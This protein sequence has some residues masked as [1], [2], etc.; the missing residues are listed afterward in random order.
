M[1]SLLVLVA[2][3]LLALPV[4]IVVALVMVAGLRRRVADLERDVQAL[5]VRR[6]DAPASAPRAGAAAQEGPAQAAFVESAPPPAAAVPPPAAPAPRP[7]TVPLPPSP[8]RGPGTVE[9]G[10]AAIRGWFTEGNVPVK[11]GVLV[12][13]AGVA[14]LLKYASDQGLLRVPVELRLAGIA[15]AATATLVFAWRQRLRRRAFALSLQGGAVGVLLLTVFGAFR[16]YGLLPPGMAFAL[17]VVLVAGACVLAVLQDAL[18]LAVFGILAGFLAPLWLSTGGGSHVALFSYYALLN[19]GVF[20]IAWWRAWRLLNL[21][22]FVFTFGIGTAWGVLA[23]TPT[24]FASTEP[25]LLL[26]FAFYL[27]I[28]VLYAR[29][30]AG[31]RDLVD[32]SLVFGTP[33]VAF[34]LQAALLDGARMPLALC[35][36]GLA[37]LYA[38]LAWTLRGRERRALLAQSHALLAVGF[39]TLAIPLAL[40]AQATASAFALEG[41]ALVW[42]GLRQ[43]RLLPQ[44]SGTALQALAA[45]AFAL[46]VLFSGPEHTPL[47]N[48]TCTSG[49]LV[50]LAGFASAWSYAAAARPRAALAW[51]VWGLAWWAGIALNEIADFVAPHLQP[52]AAFV[53]AVASGWLAAEVARR[54]PAVAL[55][56]TTAAGLAAGVAFALVQAW[57]VDQ[58][59]ALPAGWAWLAFA[60]FGARSLVALRGPASRAV[61]AAHAAWLWTWPLATSLGLHG[62][63][64]GPDVGTGWRHVAVLLPWWI[65]ALLAAARPAWLAVPLAAGFG[66][67][68]RALLAS[69]M[70]VL[71]AGWL[72][73]LFAAGAPAPLPWL[74]L[75]NPLDLMQ[76][77]ILALAVH[78]AATT[79]RLGRWRVPVLAFGA[80]ALANA[81]LLRSLHHW[82]GVIWSTS[83]FSTSLVQTALTLLW[84]VLGVAGWIVGSRRGLRTVWLAGA[85][86]MGVVL[87]KLVLV[88]RQHLGNLLGIVSFIGFG[89]L[90]TAVGFF[91]PAPPRAAAADAGAA[92]AAQ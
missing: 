30:R 22:G 19:A 91:A 42:L 50:A 58:P 85:L 20:A 39:A 79:P 54:R 27:A 61:V 6:A 37:A 53:F 43:A 63:L 7:A 10:V 41:A 56:W 45:C 8:P 70:A 3:V 92:G 89:V 36:L 62:L 34:A 52:A 33:L 80:F 57:R 2:L 46:G 78:L 5:R 24:D 51:Y 15:A 9:R 47:V 77:A 11:I 13:L 76:A 49:L 84:S 48:P 59:F 35:A 66:A 40:S 74:P 81:S 55:A 29:R 1:S 82:A 16:L 83:M 60:A 38:A 86:L 25:F 90:C 75:L 65:A 71:V 32:G 88:D 72:P 17:S 87:L 31:G 23:Y 73:A 4:A 14:A 69:Y 18:A 28:P 12:L 68:R 67:W 26:F 44:V 21:L 64:A